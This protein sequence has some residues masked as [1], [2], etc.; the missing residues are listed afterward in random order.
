M[1]EFKHK[2]CG[3]VISVDVASGFTLRTHSILLTPSEIRLGVLQLDINSEGG[4][5]A[6]FCETCHEKFDMESGLEKITSMCLVCSKQKPIEEL[7][8]SFPFPCICEGCKKE[9]SGESKAKKSKLIECFNLSTAGIVFTPLSDVL[10]KL[11]I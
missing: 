2:S 7:F 9:L 1:A 6:F 11:V 5:P 10:K 3:G 8:T 4:N